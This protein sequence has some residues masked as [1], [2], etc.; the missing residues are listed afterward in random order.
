MFDVVQLLTNHRSTLS[1]FLFDN[2]LSTYLSIMSE[3][4]QK[5]NWGESFYFPKFIMT[6]Y[7]SVA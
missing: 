5:L 1:D 4:F 7:I 6:N 2:A 3:L